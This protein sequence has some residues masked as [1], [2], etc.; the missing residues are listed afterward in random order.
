MKFKTIKILTILL[1]VVVLCT[2]A[3]SLPRKNPGGRDPFI[4]R[5][6]PDAPLQYQFLDGN[7]ISSIFY[8]SGIFNQ[9]PRAQNTPSFMWPKGTN[10]F[11]CFT[12][13]LSIGCYID[14]STESGIQKFAMAQV[15]ASYTGEYTPGYIISGGVPDP[16]GP[17]QDSRF[18]LYKIKYGDNAGNN[19]DYENWAYMVEFGAPYVDLNN[20]GVYDNGIDLA[21]QENASQTLFMTMTDAFTDQKSI[22]EGFGGG[23]YSPLLYAEVHF[24]AWCYNS[25]GL[26]DLQF[27]NWVVINKGNR[28]WT[29]TYMGVVVDPDLGQA[30]DDYIGCDTT[31]N[32]GY[33]YNGDNDDPVY[34]Q[35]PPAFGMDYFKSPIIKATNDTLGLT[36]F[37]FFTNTGS[38]P[39]PCESDP[40]GEPYPAYLMLRGLKKDSSNF[41]NPLASPPVP[42]FFVYPGDPETGAGWTEYKGSMQNCGGNTGNI[43][44]VNPLGDRRF[45]FNSGREDYTYMP[46]DTQ[47]IVLAQF[48]ARGGTNVN[49]VTKLKALSKTAQLIYDNNFNVTPPPPPPVVNITYT[50]T[51][52]GNCN[53]TF[54][55]SAISESYRYW[56]SIFFDAEDSNI[57][58]FEG[59]EI[60]EIDKTLNS[61]PDFTKPETITE[62]VTLIDIFDV[63]NNIGVVIDTFATGVQ[64]GGN[65]HYAPYPIVPPYKMTVPANFPNHGISRSVTLTS[66]KYAQNYGGQTAFIYGQEYRFAILAYAVSRADSVSIRR[67]FRVIRNSLSTQAISVRPVAPTAG[68]QYTY[69]NGDTLDVN[70][71]IRDLGLIPIVRNRELL[72]DATYRVQFNS[73]TTY[74]ILRKLNTES[75]FNPLAQNLKYVNFKS[76][77]DDSSRTID[78]IFFKLEKI[79]F[80]SDGSAGGYYGNV[81]V[82]KDL[83][84]S[85]DSIQTRKKGWDY[86][87]NNNPWFEGARLLINNQDPK[88]QSQ[89]MS[90]SYPAKQTYNS[91]GSRLKPDE[92]RVVKIVFSNNPANQQ[93]AYRYV[94]KTNLPDADPSFAPFI[95]NRATG[96]NNYPYQDKRTVPFTVWEIDPNDSSSAPRQL[97][98]AFLETNDTIPRGLVDGQWNPTAD[99]TGSNEYL[100]IFNSTYGDAGWDAFYTNPSRNLY[101]SVLMD[102]M[103]VWA[104]KRINS[105]ATFTNN[106]EFYIYPYTVT[107]P[108]VASNVPTTPLFYEFTT[109]APKFGN[110]N[111]ASETNALTKIKVVPNPYYGF[112][113]LDRSLSDKFI[114][115]R[116]MPVKCT[117]KLYTINGDLIRTLYK[118]NSSSTIEWDL[119]NEDRVPIASGIYVALIDAPGIGQKVMKL[120]VFTSQERINF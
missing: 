11:A 14:T 114:T 13:G 67:G 28:P 119:Q 49:S 2:D 9:D 100:Y 54:N 74:N 7:N 4:N 75:S 17:S 20:N 102:V 51:I 8:N 30:E 110:T 93:L 57:Y 18:K 91:V 21:G 53:I 104:A 47:N 68:T 83:T 116:H 63:R 33:C 39:P 35:A 62:N 48:V 36:S 87:P 19:P 71:P 72:R 95:I 27:L 59:Y 12:A 77:T 103:Y 52:A 88:W 56:D 55:W 3:F 109:I 22:G 96:P 117:I 84:L 118:D 64:V 90:I 94:A 43:I 32:L 73:D 34:G 78:G 101:L 44:N 41:M 31:L 58:Y 40:N 38:S 1:A 112:S 79:R 70:Y 42:T 81:G 76:T 99:S 113:T 108:Y 61:Y 86:L 5:M 46:N 37:V 23:V 15:M 16:V 69:N 107:R 29:R 82:I 65:D 98:C 50:P 92:L 120:V 10:Q 97:N 106:D 115:F 45:I 66:T 25:P 105:T 26:E 80:T 24:T 111:Y 60:Y 85:A 89:S 6:T